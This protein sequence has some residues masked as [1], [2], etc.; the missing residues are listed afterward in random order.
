MAKLLGKCL[1]IK[2]VVRP[3]KVMRCFFLTALTSVDFAGLNMAPERYCANSDLVW[4]NLM[5]PL[6][7]GVRRAPYPRLLYVMSVSL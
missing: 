3:G 2:F 6:A 5:T 4:S 1:E 7:T